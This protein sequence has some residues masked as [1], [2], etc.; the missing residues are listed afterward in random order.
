MKTFPIQ[1][2]WRDRELYAELPRRLPWAIWEPYR[3]QIE[4]N[5]GGQT[6]E[7]LVERHGLSPMELWCGITNRDLQ[8]L[9]TNS[10]THEETRDGI[11]KRLA[12]LKK[13]PSQ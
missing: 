1:I 2:S 11:L 7:R 8:P 9:F 5:H 4:R 13:D 3:K 6:L 12:E 10:M